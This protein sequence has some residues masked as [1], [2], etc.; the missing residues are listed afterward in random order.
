MDNLIDNRI[1][2]V[3]QTITDTE[4]KEAYK[5]AETFTLIP[6]LKLIYHTTNI[7]LSKDYKLKIPLSSTNANNIPINEIEI[8]YDNNPTVYKLYLDLID[9]SYNLNVILLKHH[10]IL[11]SEPIDENTKPTIQYKDQILEI[12]TFLVHSA[13][14]V[15]ENLKKKYPELSEYDITLDNDTT[16]YLNPQKPLRLGLNILAKSV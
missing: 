3:S 11:K 13:K 6:L 14:L 2:Q 1:D 8:K 4:I 12:M 5:N 15:F 16:I 9:S 10:L 7:D